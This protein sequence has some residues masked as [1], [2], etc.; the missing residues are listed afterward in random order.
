MMVANRNRTILDW[1]GWDRRRSRIAES[2]IRAITTRG[3]YDGPMLRNPR[4]DLIFGDW[5]Y[6]QERY[7]CI[8]KTF[9]T[10]RLSSFILISTTE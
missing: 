10:R 8:G 4:G 9:E 2:R 7:S 6:A 5:Q 1:Y 3:V